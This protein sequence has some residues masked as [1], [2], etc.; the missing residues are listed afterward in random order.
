MHN[1]SNKKLRMQKINNIFSSSFGFVNSFFFKTLNPKDFIGKIWKKDMKLPK[2]EKL[3]I[4]NT[5]FP[6]EEEI[7]TTTNALIIVVS[8]DN[9]ILEINYHSSN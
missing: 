1:F 6:I 3:F 9:I 8:K 5:G 2:H 7:K 4:V